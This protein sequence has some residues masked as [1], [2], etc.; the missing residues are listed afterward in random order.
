MERWYEEVNSGM[1]HDLEHHPTMCLSR[2]C[3]RIDCAGCL[4][5]VVLDAH[6]KYI[7]EKEMKR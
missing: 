2:N 7:A 5:A 3:G 1:I 4:D 6:K